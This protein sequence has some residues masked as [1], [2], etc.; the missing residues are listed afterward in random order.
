MWLGGSC[1]MDDT[2]FFVSN[3]IRAVVS[4]CDT[5]PSMEVINA[6][7][8]SVIHVDV[9]DVQT[10]NLLRFFA[11][12]AHFVQAARTGHLME[13]NGHL[14]TLTHESFNDDASL[15]NRGCSV[16]K[17]SATGSDEEGEQ[18]ANASSEGV[19]NPEN[20]STIE[21]TKTDSQNRRE[22]NSK[23]RER[24]EESLKPLFKRCFVSHV[25]LLTTVD[26]KT[27][28]LGCL[29]CIIGKES[30][31]GSGKSGMW[32]D[33]EVVSNTASSDAFPSSKLSEKQNFV[34]SVPCAKT[35][36][37]GN[38][39]GRNLSWNGQYIPPTG[40]YIHCQ[41]GISRS[42]TTF[43]SYLMVW[44]GFTVTE[45]LGHIHRRR[46]CICPNS[47]FREQLERFEQQKWFI[48]MLNESLIKKFGE[49]SE[50]RKKDLSHV[51]LVMAEAAKKGSDRDK[52]YTENFY[53][54]DLEE[55]ERLLRN[56]LRPLIKDVEKGIIS[57]NVGL[58]WLFS[59]DKNNK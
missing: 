21:E 20:E 26:V 23:L 40:V 39:V 47:G 43:C 44:L 15:N 53:K 19:E 55:Q 38:T 52:H 4:V 46:E 9:Q 5:H 31:D 33:A 51:A 29:C 32:D 6:A 56:R 14:E 18:S 10:T 45:A 57:D 50:L 28:S 12:V 1:V 8:L 41:A 36:L 48:S 24:L 13:T 7:K 3:G 17:E 37:N 16:P 54:N 30:T 2:Q 59:N 11:R 34:N 35:S 58:K 25:E 42:T 22:L 27:T 49:S